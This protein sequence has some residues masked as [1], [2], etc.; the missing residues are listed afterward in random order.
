M[1]TALGR[2]ITPDGEST[3]GERQKQLIELNIRKTDNLI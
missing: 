2:K 1:R 3:L